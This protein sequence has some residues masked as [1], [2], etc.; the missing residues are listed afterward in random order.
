MF[1]HSSDHIDSSDWYNWCIQAENDD[2]KDNVTVENPEI[3]DKVLD[4]DDDINTEEF[5]ANKTVE[6]PNTLENFP[7]PIITGNRAPPLEL[8]PRL[9]PI[10]KTVKR[11]QKAVTA[12]SLPNLW[13]ANH[14]SLWPRK[15]W[16]S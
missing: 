10:R 2:F 7:I 4:Y 14:R 5:V 9:A 8:E 6:Y 15:S 3:D 13:A 16:W 11:N 1:S 12:L